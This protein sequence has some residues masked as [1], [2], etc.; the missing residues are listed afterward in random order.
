MARPLFFEFPTDSNTYAIDKQFM[1]G[2]GL[3]ITPVLDQGATT[4]TGLLHVNVLFQDILRLAHGGS[5]T[6]TT[7]P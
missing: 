3:M 7:H 2:S 4:V 1:I 5:T 6:G